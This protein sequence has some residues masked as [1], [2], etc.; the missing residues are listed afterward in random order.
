MSILRLSRALLVCNFG[1]SRQII[2]VVGGE[3]EW[4]LEIWTAAGIYG[5]TQD[6]QGPPEVLSLESS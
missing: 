6:Q 5:G 2:P 3:T 4:R 1:D